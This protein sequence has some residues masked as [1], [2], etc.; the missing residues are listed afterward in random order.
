MSSIVPLVLLHPAG[1]AVAVIVDLT[2]GVV[3]SCV[4][5]GSRVIEPGVDCTGIIEPAAALRGEQAQSSQSKAK[6]KKETNH[7]K[8]FT[9]IRGKMAKQNFTLRSS[10]TG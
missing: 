10:L 1:M 6:L 3:M 7:L 9:F 4:M 5:A 8:Q 2:T